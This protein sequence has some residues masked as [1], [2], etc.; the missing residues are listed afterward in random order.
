MKLRAQT[1]DGIELRIHVTLTGYLRV[2]PSGEIDRVEIYMPPRACVECDKIEHDALRLRRT[3]W[4]EPRD[5]CAD[6]GS[7]VSPEDLRAESA[8]VLEQRRID[9]MSGPLGDNWP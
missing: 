6:D 2:H 5:L 3:L 7:S 9:A 4:A 8:R 1:L